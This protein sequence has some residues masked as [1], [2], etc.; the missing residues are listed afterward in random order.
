[1]PRPAPA[2]ELLGDPEGRG[3]G[4]LQRLG[5]R[6]LRP[7]HVER[8]LR[9]IELGARDDVVPDQLRGAIVLRRGVGEPGARR[10]E[11][12][13]HL[14]HARLEHRWIQLREQLPR[15][16]AITSRNV[17]SQQDARRARA[18]LHLCADTRPNHAG[19]ENGGTDVAA[20]DHGRA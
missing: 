10:P 6:H 2:W 18:D 7:G 15:G 19:G 14:I 8:A 11:L 17:Q 12:R 20:L 16:H 3:I 13:R 4:A 9:A 5:L 1:M